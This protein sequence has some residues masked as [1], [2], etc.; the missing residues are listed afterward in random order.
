MKEK[1]RMTRA[2]LEIRPVTLR[3]AKE[4]VAQNHRHHLPPQGHKFS[5]GLYAGDRMVGCAIC[6]RPVSRYLDNNEICEITRLCTDGTENAC[7]MLYGAC[8]R[9]AREMG[10]KKM[11]TYTLASENGASLRAVSN[12]KVL[13]AGK[14]GQGPG[15]RT[16]AFQKRKNIVGPGF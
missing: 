3:Q 4:F 7:S 15:K 13:P 16:M 8:C 11:I 6:G 1:K 10:Y 2:G 12:V 5:I 14:C 9:I